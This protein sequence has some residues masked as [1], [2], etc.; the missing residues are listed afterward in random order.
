MTEPE[1]SWGRLILSLQGAFAGRGT[2]YGAGETFMQD[3]D[4]GAYAP[5][6]TLSRFN[7]LSAPSD[8]RSRKVLLA[9][10]ALISY[11]AIVGDVLADGDSEDQKISTPIRTVNDGTG[12]ERPPTDFPSIPVQG[13][14]LPW[15]RYSSFAPQFYA[16]N[17][18]QSVGGGFA[19]TE[20]AK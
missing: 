11:G 15:E 20:T 3:A 12:G 19:G 14:R 2:T 13:H 8:W 17:V 18:V 16:S 7:D 9:L 6:G 10:T 4:G 5:A 1:R